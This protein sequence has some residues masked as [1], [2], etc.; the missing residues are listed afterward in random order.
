MYNVPGTRTI[1]I[2]LAS[3]EPVYKQIVSALRTHLVNERIKPG[4]NLPPVR[5]LAVELG[6]HFN[7]VAEAYRM[8]ADE[9]WLELRRRRGALV[10]DRETP[11]PPQKQ[12]RQSF[13]KRLDEIV[14]EALAQGLA[15]RQVAAALARSADGLAG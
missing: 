8:L 12:E 5:Q 3:P 4:E 7:T 2:D 6:V 13:A 11:H 9:G 15:P 14:A 1:R 10:L